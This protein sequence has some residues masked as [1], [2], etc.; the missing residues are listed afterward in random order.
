VRVLAVDTTLARCSVALVEDDR[1]LAVRSDAM[2]R[3]HAERIAPMADEVMGEAGATF[4]SVD[5]IVVTTGPGSFTGLRVGLAFARGLAVA[6]NK[7]CVGVSSLHA[8]ALERGMHG[9][10]GAAIQGGP[11]MFAA[12][13]QDGL[14]KLPPS[15]M[16]E[17]DARAALRG[18]VVRGPAAELFGGDVA[19]APD[20][21]ALALLGAGLDPN[22]YPP[23]PLYLRDADA[24]LPSS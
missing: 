12:L 17:A 2:T 9:L 13:Y 14:E 15:R 10:H 21:V 23:D 20:I 1:A 11:D 8:L 24:K 4:A 6:L 22:T 16:S 7:P 19:D 3:G 18:A 5:R